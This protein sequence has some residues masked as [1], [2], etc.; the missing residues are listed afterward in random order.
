MISNPSTPTV[1]WGRDLA[2]LALIF[3]ALFLFRLGSAPLGEPDE[4]RYAEIPREMVA[5]G[6]WVTPRLDGVD[7]FEKPPLVYWM[8]ASCL[9]IFGGSEWS[10]R[11]PAALFGIGGVLATYAA[12]RRIYGRRAGMMGAVALGTSTLYFGLA[13]ILVLDGAVAVLM[14][15]TLFCFILGI[16]EE[17]GC[18]RRWLFY[19]LYASSA[20]A[21]MT[22]GPIGFLVTGA[23]M[24]LWLLLMDQWKR[25]RPLHL[26]SGVLVFLAIA[27]PWHLLAASRNPSWAHFYFIHENWERFTTTEHGRTGPWWYFVPI[28]ILGLF[29]WTGFLWSALREKLAGGWT[30]RG[31]NAEAWFLAIWAAFIFVFFSKSQSKLPGYILPVFPPL[32]VLIGAGLADATAKKSAVPRSGLWGFVGLAGLLGAAALAIAANPHLLHDPA[33]G[34][35]LQPYAWRLAAILLAGGL[36]VALMTWA[37]K[38]NTAILGLLVVTVLFFCELSS[39]RPL[40]QRPSTKELALHLKVR[41][42]PGD[43]IVHYHAFFRDFTFYSGREADLAAYKDEL[44][45]ENDPSAAAQAHFISDAEFRRRW[46][47]SGRV[48]AVAKKDDIKELLADPAFHYRLLEETRG[49]YLI[50]NQP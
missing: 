19:G 40:I 44:E 39:A 18:R 37:G 28:V 2:V 38:S 31:E 16:R 47:G 23:V 42:A 17:P 49:H 22:K 25:L 7:Y 33:Q 13:R 24:F 20:L 35:A 48:F 43:E 46:A 5:T 27:L 45:P 15:A 34:M 11:L 12:G 26:P 41:G 50:V 21:T 14:S 30:R 29:P 6:D 4:G 10:M 8:T 36:T 9:E 1:R 3:G 32:A